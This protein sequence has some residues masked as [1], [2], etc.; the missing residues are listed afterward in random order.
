MTAH[1]DVSQIEPYWFGRTA[2]E[3]RAVVEARDETWAAVPGYSRYEWSDKGRW[4]RL[5]YTDGLG[6]KLAAKI[7]KTPPDSG[8]YVTV[9]FVNDKGEKCRGGV[10]VM[11]QLAHHPAFHGLD[12]FP[13]GLETRHN[14]AIGDKT[15]N[16]YPE[17]IWPGTK[18]E[19]NGIDKDPQEPQHPC[20]NAPA[21]ENMSHT[22]G[23]RCASCATAV[24]IEA[25]ALL[26]ARMNLMAV[27]RLFR[28][29]GPDWVYAQ[30]VKHGGYEGT[31]SDALA[32]SPTLMQR[33]RLRGTLRV[34]EA[35]ESAAERAGDAT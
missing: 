20:R 16:A 19:N 15:F 9:N 6:R 29:A 34:I 28:Y 21:C 13:D 23:K 5:A 1:S 2:E 12:R 14:P 17:G 27:A 18:A 10:H 25:A 35:R 22:K 4:R 11:V 33:A 3:V 7:L 26:R 32:Q 31:K 24:G 8:G 30:A